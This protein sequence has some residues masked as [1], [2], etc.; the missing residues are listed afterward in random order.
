MEKAMRAVFKALPEH[1]SLPGCPFFL[2]MGAGL[3]AL[4]CDWVRLS[5]NQFVGRARCNL[6]SEM[7]GG[8]E[9]SNAR[10]PTHSTC[11][12]KMSG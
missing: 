6:C 7:Q 4:Y 8:Q 10:A 3:F 2:S 11:I 12:E 5:F 9:I 1:S